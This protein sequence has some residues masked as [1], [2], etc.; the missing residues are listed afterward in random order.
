MSTRRAEWGYGCLGLLLLVLVASYLVSRFDPARRRATE[1]E[2]QRE[3]AE[4]R[5]EAAATFTD[6]VPPT[7]DDV[8]TFRPVLDRLGTALNRGDA[9]A[10]NRLFDSDKLVD[11]L[12]RIGAFDQIREGR[13]SQFVAGVRQGAKGLLGNALLSNELVRWE[14]TEIRRVRWAAD[15]KQAVVICV[16]R[17]GGDDD[18]PFKMRWW[19]ASGPDGWKIYDL[20]DLAIG[21]R[22]SHLIRMT[23]TPDAMEMLMR[24][25]DGLRTAMADVRAALVAIMMKEDVAEGEAALARARNV[26]LPGVGEA[27]RSM[28]EGHLATLKGDPQAALAHFAETDRRL[29]GMPWVALGRGM[30]HNVAQEY[31]KALEQ[32]RKYVAE[33]GPDAASAMVEGTALVGLGRDAEALPLARLA[34]DEMPDA[35]LGYMLLRKALPPGDKGELSDR[36]AKCRKIDALYPKLFSDAS[37]EGDAAGA[38]ALTAGLRKARPDDPRW[39]CDDIREKVRGKKFAEATDLFRDRLKAAKTDADRDQ[40]LFA[41]LYAMGAEDKHAEAYAAVP[42]AHATTAF[43]VLARRMEYPILFPPKKAEGEKQLDLKALLTGLMADHRKRE[44]RDPALWYFDG[45]LLQ[46]AKEFEKAEK[47]YAEGQKLAAAAPKP[48]APR[49]RDPDD[50]EDDEDFTEGRFRRARIGVMFEAGKGLAAYE[51]IGPPAD[52]FRDL[53]DRYLDAPDAD[54]LEKLVA[55]HRKKVPADATLPLWDAEV[56]YLRKDYARAADGYKAYRKALGEKA[57][58]RWRVESQWVRSLLRSGD[59]AAAR[60]AISEIGADHLSAGLRLAVT[61]A[62]GSPAALEMALEE[63]SKAPGG[64]FG[65]YYDEDFVVEF[66]AKKY[67]AVR[68]KYPDPRPKQ[69]AGPGA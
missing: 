26:R 28:A 6:P 21:S 67:D 1:D 27:V 14:K 7:P 15:R 61:A 59:A 52:T 63:Q 32:A 9:A 33:V 36:L 11:E 66:G 40:Y 45:V 3:R 20:E 4:D 16:H 8:T 22:L 51:L 55:A 69:P 23:M 57:D 38:A 17:S 30:A 19:L 39:A 31:D 2:V 25:P 60:R 10:A 34:I 46:G 37:A 35:E 54:G 56:K 44:P 42:P 62:E 41:Y 49:P 43:R 29:P 53:A 5:R 18:T 13:N 65:V 47:V 64:L 50:D 12:F 24:N 48:K 58:D 68:A